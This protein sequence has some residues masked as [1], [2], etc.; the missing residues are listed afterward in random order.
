[1]LHTARVA[2]LIRFALTDWALIAACWVLLAWADAWWLFPVAWLV[3]A[4]RFHALGVV[5]H[6]ACHMRAEQRHS[7]LMPVLELLA[8]YPIGTSLAA[9]RYHHLRHH[10]YSGGTEDPYLKVGISGNRGQRNLRRVLG[11]LLVPGWIVRTFYGSL[12][13]VMPKL[14]NSYARLFLQDRGGRDVTRS[15]EVLRCLKSEPPQALLFAALI[16]ASLHFPAMVVYY[17]VP[18]FL[19][20][21][22]NVNRV[23]VEHVHVSCADRRAQAIYRTAVTHDQGALGKVFLYP[24]NIGFHQAHHLYPT[25]ALECLPALHAHLK[26]LASDS[27]NLP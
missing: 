6:D 1:V 12:A 11:L 2:T 8:G 13:L 20:G 4:G 17:F 9:M 15:A 27:Q 23:I 21:A 18:L 3:I 19:A 16:A 5:L 25:A 14:R 26:R 10:R 22:L 24:R 7:G